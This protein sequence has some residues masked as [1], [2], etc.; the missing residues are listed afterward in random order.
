MAY[1][2]KRQKYLKREASGQLV[3]ITSTDQHP[4]KHATQLGHVASHA[5]CVGRYGAERLR[6]SLREKLREK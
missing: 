1:A 3:Q 5:A 6:E 2:K 4:I